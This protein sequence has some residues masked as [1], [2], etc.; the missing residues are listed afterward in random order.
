MPRASTTPS[1]SPWTWM[2]TMPCASIRPLLVTFP[3]ITTSVAADVQNAR[4][5]SLDVNRRVVFDG[6][7]LGDVCLDQ[8]DA[9]A[10]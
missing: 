9:V 1:M 8:N 5:V 10:E 2:A 7:R 3:P 4:E 6:Q